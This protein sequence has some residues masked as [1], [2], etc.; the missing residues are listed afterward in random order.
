[1]GRWGVNYLYG[2]WCVVQ[3]LAMIHDEKTG[4]AIGRAIRW[5]QSVQ[6]PDGGWGESCLSDKENRYLPLEVSVPSQ[7]AWAVMTLIAAGKR[8]SESCRR[9][10]DF[11]IASQT[12]DGRWEERH[13]TGTGF[14]GHF[15]IR[16]HGYRQYFPLLALGKYRTDKRELKTIACPA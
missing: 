3:G 10:I 15:Y 7:T 12:A 13:F 14:P 1:R 8:S 9:G 6:N 16:Y 2:T 5:L 4:L 11:L